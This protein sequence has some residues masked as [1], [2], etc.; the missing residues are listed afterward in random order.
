VD[1]MVVV[2]DRQSNA[3]V[4]DDA[5][6]K[7]TKF[8]PTGAVQWTIDA[9]SGPDPDLVGHIHRG[10]FD[11]QDHLWLTNDGNSRVVAIDADGHKVDAFGA[12]GTGPG[13]FEG[14]FSIA[15]DASGNAY[16]DE[17]S[18]KRLQ[19]LDPQHEVI[20]VFNAP[21]GLPFGDNYAVGRD[22]LLYAI[23]GGDHCAG[24]APSG[25]AAADILVMQVALPEAANASLEGTWQTAP[26]TKDDLRRALESA[27][28]PADGIE[29]FLANQG[30]S[31]HVVWSIG[32][33]GGKWVLYGSADDAVKDIQAHGNYEVV[34]GD[35]VIYTDDCGAITFDYAVAA[36]K[37]T[38]H[39]T[40]DT[41]APGTD[42]AY[43]AAAI[44]NTAPFARVP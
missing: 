13:Q 38:L 42:E 34:D 22:G 19:V 3:Y 15:F 4:V 2:V 23:A 26:L 12:H 25:A 40:D 33:D 24:T 9:S 8:D 5:Q 21:G 37:L 17:C 16:V 44:Y 43:Y 7:L 1:P 32:L 36:D 20:G 30:W 41:C 6:Q 18:D 27:A 28:L 31:D 10:A 14:T 35:T 39:A 29:T 11:S